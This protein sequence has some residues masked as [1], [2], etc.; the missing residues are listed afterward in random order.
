VEKYGYLTKEGELLLDKTATVDIYKKETVEFDV[1]SLPKNYKPVVFAPIPEF[2]QETQA[3]YQ[4]Q[5]VD[6]GDVIDVGVIVV[7]LPEEEGKV[8]EVEPAIKK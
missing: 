3:V 4:D 8:E 7:D 5:P 1:K 6:K 2:D